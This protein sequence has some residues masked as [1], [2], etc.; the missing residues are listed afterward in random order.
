M[1]HGYSGITVEM[2]IGVFFATQTC[3]ITHDILRIF[4]DQ[5]FY[6]M[7]IHKNKK[8]RLLLKII[9]EIK[10]DTLNNWNNK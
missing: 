1:Q 4:T 8:N 3:A 5:N 10:I 6:K 2:Y 7:E 9:M